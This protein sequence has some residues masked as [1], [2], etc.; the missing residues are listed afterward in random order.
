MPERQIDIAKARGELI[1]ASDSAYARHCSIENL[2]LALSLRGEGVGSP[3]GADR[4]VGGTL[5]E[6][7][8]V[9]PELS[10]ETEAEYERVGLQFR[11]FFVA[12]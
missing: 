6:S 7:E 1:P 2:L 10:R 12:L 4:R 11:F 9:S 3:L 8:D 5:G